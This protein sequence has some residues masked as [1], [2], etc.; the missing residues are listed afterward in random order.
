[1]GEGLRAVF[2]ILKWLQIEIETEED[3]IVKACRV[4]LRG[5]V[6]QGAMPCWERRSMAAWLVASASAHRITAV[7]AAPP[8]RRCR[9]TTLACIEPASNPAL[10]TF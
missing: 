9:L 10:W 7:A 5:S 6:M 2:S 8:G 4:L 3:L 1:V